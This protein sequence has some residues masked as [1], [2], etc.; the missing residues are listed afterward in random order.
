MSLADDEQPTPVILN[1]LGETLRGLLHTVCRHLPTDFGPYGKRERNA[2]DCSCGCRHF[3]ELS[4]PLNLDWG[5]CTNPRGPRSG[6][7][8][9]EH[10]GCEFFECDD[11][12]VDLE[13]VWE[14]ELHKKEF[15]SKILVCHDQ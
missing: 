6:L 10:Q 1:D 12:A 8:T 4:E 14:I 9:F 5:V 3:L 11:T 7:L 2:A 15:P 13:L